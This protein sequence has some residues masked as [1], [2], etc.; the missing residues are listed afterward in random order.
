MGYPVKFKYE[1]W[2]TDRY[3]RNR[4]GVMTVVSVCRFT[5]VQETKVVII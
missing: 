2:I 5:G 3:I 4:K 1:R